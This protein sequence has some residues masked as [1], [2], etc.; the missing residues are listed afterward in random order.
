MYGAIALVVT[1]FHPACRLVDKTRSALGQYFATDTP[2]STVTF[3][4]RI[5]QR[6]Q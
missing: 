1:W 5:H 2:T 3:T 4:P 6:L